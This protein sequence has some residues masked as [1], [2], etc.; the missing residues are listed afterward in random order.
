MEW[1]G[2]MR[3]ASILSTYMICGGVLLL[4]IRSTPA[5]DDVYCSG[6]VGWLMYL[7]GTL[8]SWMDGW[9]DGDSQCPVGVQCSGGIWRYWM[10]DDG[11]LLRTCA[12]IG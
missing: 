7:R 9:M 4:G 2:W 8:G 11:C 12:M 6:L 5:M 3:L 10:L 1:H